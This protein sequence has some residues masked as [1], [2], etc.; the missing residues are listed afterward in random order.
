MIKHLK[1]ITSTTTIPYDNMALES[2]LLHHVSQGEC[3]LYLWQKDVYK[4]QRPPWTA[5]MAQ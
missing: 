3:I 1:T 2:Y 4:R 5:R